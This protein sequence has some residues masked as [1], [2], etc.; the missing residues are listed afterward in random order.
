MISDRSGYQLKGRHM[1][2]L[3][4]PCVDLPLSFLV[5]VSKAIFSCLPHGSH[6]NA[7]DCIIF[8]LH[9]LPACWV[10]AGL[11]AAQ[12]LLIGCQSDTPL[13]MSLP[14]YTHAAFIS[15]MP[16]D[17]WQPYIFLLI[18]RARNEGGLVLC[19]KMTT[20]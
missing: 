12:F 2:Y 14:K 15:L 1:L 20:Q 10:D 5:S 19:L 8:S 13:L 17:R 18:H 4:T 6:N 7:N 3:I 16:L 11:D 9:L